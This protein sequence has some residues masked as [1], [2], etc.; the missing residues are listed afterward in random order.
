MIFILLKSVTKI[1][2]LLE[3]GIERWK[4]CFLCKRA[5]RYNIPIHVSGSVKIHFLY[6]VLFKNV[7]HRLYKRPSKEICNI[8]IVVTAGLPVSLCKL[9]WNLW[10]PL[11][12]RDTPCRFEYNSKEGLWPH[13][14][15]VRIWK[16]CKRNMNFFYRNL[17]S[18]KY[19]IKPISYR[20]M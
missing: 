1:R 17:Q 3:R 20:S 13:E 7:F 16:C 19:C 18:W 8:K 12:A 15:P 9:Y 6:K 10:R 14:N 11:K 2:S 4:S 5:N